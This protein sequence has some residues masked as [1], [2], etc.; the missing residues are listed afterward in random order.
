[1]TTPGGQLTPGDQPEIND[2]PIY[3]VPDGAYVGEAASPQS[4]KDLNG[5]TKETAKQRMQAPL[6]GVFQ[7]QKGALAFFVQGVLGIVQGAINLVVGT[8]EAVVGGIHAIAASI[9]SLFGMSHRD[10]R[11]V[12]QARVAA[13]NAIVAN[14]GE[15]LDQFDEVQRAGGA[16]MDYPRF[17][18]SN[19]G[20]TPHVLPLS[21]GMTLQQGTRWVGPLSPLTHPSGDTYSST[22]ANYARMATG[23]G[24]LE[25][26]ESGFW[27]IDFQ[28]SVLQAGGYYAEPAE[29][30]C[31][32]TSAAEVGMPY[33]AP[34][35]E[36]DGSP[37]SSPSLNLSR[38]RTTG[39]KGVMN[40]GIA[41]FGRA[42]SYVDQLESEWSGGNTISGS[43][44]VLLP[45]GGY[46]VTMAC[47]AYEHFSG[48][49]STFVMATKIN[50]ESLRDDIDVLKTQIAAALPGRSVPLDLS[51][52]GIAAMVSQAQEIEVSGVEVP[53]G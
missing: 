27:R 20:R 49:A 34:G 40:G 1:M 21:H 45:T 51:D 24:Y 32:V 44:F 29:V 3:G 22:E 41:A 30:W 15:A 37:A 38:S 6:E 17:E 35:L 5:L 2:P 19:G 47:S 4:I 43:V 16:Y 42:S 50:S 53:R 31:Y 13:E 33:G 52:A 10:T 12:D 28:A 11:A 9:G 48:G 8:V 7:S 25:L 36:E 18:L 23:S 39:A 46:K 14:L 26:L